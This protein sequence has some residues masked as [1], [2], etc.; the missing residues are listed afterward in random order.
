MR[1]VWSLLSLCALL[2]GIATGRAL[3]R[4]SGNSRLSSTAVPEAVPKLAASNGK[5]SAKGKPQGP[6]VTDFANR[7]RSLLAKLGPDDDTIPLILSLR[8]LARRDASAALALLRERAFPQRAKVFS[9]LMTQVFEH[10]YLQM[11]SGLFS[12]VLATFEGDPSMNFDKDAVRRAFEYLGRED[13][14][15]AWTEAFGKERPFCMSAVD[16]LLVWMEK[17]DRRAVLSF[18]DA[19]PDSTPRTAAMTE[20][21]RRWARDDLGKVLAWMAEQPKAAARLRKEWLLDA[22]PHSEEELIALNRL[23]GESL[24]WVK[25]DRLVQA[26]PKTDN[27]FKAL[28]PSLLRDHGLAVSFLRTWGGDLDGVA[29]LMPEIQ[30]ASARRL[31]T[32]GAAVVLARKD[33]AAAYKFIATLGETSQMLAKRSIAS[34]MEEEMAP[35]AIAYYEAHPEA[36]DVNTVGEFGH[37]W[38]EH[39]APAMARSALTMKDEELRQNMLS[40]AMDVWVNRDAKG[41]SKWVLEMPAGVQRDD[42]AGAIAEAAMQKSPVDGM[43]WALSIADPKHRQSAAKV[44]FSR[45]DDKAAAKAWAEQA[46]IDDALR[47]ALLARLDKEE[48]D[49]DPLRLLHYRENSDPSLHVYLPI[50]PSRRP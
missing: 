34:S 50:F 38:A 25:A 22:V 23:G 1:L 24:L 48:P 14:A 44:A 9:A 32:S 42:A 15:R 11:P 41:A 17:Q 36:L 49:P 47:A 37:T 2:L 19:Q 3:P 45:W 31:L 8:E 4:V 21:V 16:G 43:T 39:D 18:L 13:F 46:A 33:M 20:V 40:S 28:P 12:E 27:W 6:S 29:H 35:S 10:D 26:M 30:D 7:W 5:D